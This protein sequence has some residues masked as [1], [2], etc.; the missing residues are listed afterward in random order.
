[1]KEDKRIVLTEKPLFFVTPIIS[2]HAVLQRDEPIIIQGGGKP[3]KS[4]MAELIEEIKLCLDSYEHEGSNIKGCPYGIKQQGIIEKDGKWKLEFPPLPVGGPYRIQITSEGMK[5]TFSDIFIGDVWLLSGQSN[6]QLPFERVKYRFPKE[7]REGASSLIRQFNVPIGWN[8]KEVTEVL[9]EGNWICAGPEDIPQFSAVGFFFAQKLRKQY[10][11]PVGL[12]LTAVGGTP[13]EAWMSK[14][15]LE[16]YPEQLLEAKMFTNDAYIRQIQ[17][18]DIARIEAW[19]RTL[20]ESDKG[21]KKNW[22]LGSLKVDEVPEILGSKGSIEQLEEDEWRHIDLSKS[23]EDDPELC[24]A[25][26]VWLRKEIEI[27]PERAGK[28]L[29]FSFG[30]VTDADFTYINGKEIGKIDY[31][32][33]PR[34]YEVSGLL[35]GKNIIVI[36]VVAVHGTGGFTSGK[37]HVLIWKEDGF[38]QEIS[39]GWEYCRGAVME[40]L[41]EQT[42]LERKPLGMYQGMI[43]P[44]HGFAIKGICWYQGEMNADDDTSYPNYFSK[45]IGDWRK[46][47]GKEHL[48]VLFVQLPNYDMEDAGNWVNFRNMQQELAHIHDT[49]M[50]VSI[51]CGE[52]NDLHPVNKKTVGERLAMAAFQKAYGETGPWLSP[53]FSF[54]E[55]RGAKLILHFEH[56]EDGLMTRDNKDI[57]ELEIC[58]CPEENGNRAGE[59]SNRISIKAESKIEGNTVVVILPKERLPKISAVRYAWSNHPTEANLCNKVGLPVAPFGCLMIKIK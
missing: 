19:W 33:P 16:N 12:I 2:D 18:S 13:I 55:K 46:K 37:E 35:Q 30:T 47:W 11:V 43:A 39:N 54:A 24:Q 22:A 5:F 31:K 51:D 58:L 59:N 34:E 32:Y 10:D 40:P 4:I 7:Y 49:A 1:M 41:L 14:E 8:F 25:G 27:S 52:D 28:S 26:S 38:C 57:K 9:S 45:M 36:R 29:R 3:G 20:N 6:M 23:W 53:L 50:V 48:P 56:A 44:L 15:A 17:E 42:F 21:I